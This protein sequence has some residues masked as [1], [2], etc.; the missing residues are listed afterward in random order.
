MQSGLLKKI[1]VVAAVLIGVW[2]GVKYLLPVAL[3]FLL[4]GNSNMVLSLIGIALFSMTMPV[5]VAILVSV[6]PKQPGFAFGLTTLGLFVGVAPAFFI[7]PETLL[8]HQ[9]VVVIL[10]AMA[11]P[12]V[13]LCIKKG[14]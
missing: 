4:G 10:T 9:I 6:F 14:K 13:V 3:P 11:L 12:A 1:L 2:L 8:A 7:R 5:T